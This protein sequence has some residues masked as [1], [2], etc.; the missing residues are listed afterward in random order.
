MIAYLPM[1]EYL[2]M[3]SKFVRFDDTWAK[4]KCLIYSPFVPDVR[5]NII[6]S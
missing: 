3:L 2:N 6:C 1:F 5:D 4:S